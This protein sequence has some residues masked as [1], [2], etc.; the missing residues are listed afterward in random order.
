MLVPHHFSVP[1]VTRD[2]QMFLINFVNI[3]KQFKSKPL[4]KD[5]GDTH[6]QILVHIDILK[7]KGE[8][9]TTASSPFKAHELVDLM[10][11]RK[12]DEPYLEF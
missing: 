9:D 1:E 10:A 5:I 7:F 8:T 4:R 2:S 12:K 11:G 3:V 6:I